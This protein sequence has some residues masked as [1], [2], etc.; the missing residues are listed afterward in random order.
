MANLISRIVTMAY[1]VKHLKKMGSLFAN[2]C[3][4]LGEGNFS[5]LL[6]YQTH[7]FVGLKGVV[8]RILEKW[9]PLEVWCENR[10]RQLHSLIDSITDVNTKSQAE[11][12]DQVDNLL[13]MYMLQLKVQDLSKLFRS[14]Q[15]RSTELTYLSELTP[16]ASKT[17][18]LLSTLF[19][20]NL[21]ARYTERKVI[22]T[23]AYI[24][25]ML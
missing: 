15:S 20:K 8:Q 24:P 1:Q 22:A 21:F 5:Q 12:A 13:A 14:Y 11:A 4:M 19:H 2:L 9:R 16:L 25:E 6:A 7:Q 3:E 18:H 10:D 23:S 17:R